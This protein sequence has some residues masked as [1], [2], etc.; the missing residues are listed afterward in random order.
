MS[1][2]IIPFPQELKPTLPTIEGNVDYRQLR[3][4]LHC[5]DQLLIQSKLEQRFVE[6]S[7]EQWMARGQLPADKI[8]PNGQLK[9]QIHSRLAL[10]CN[11]LRTYLKEDFRGFAVRLADS[12]LFQ[13][14]CGLSALDR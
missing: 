5:I 6:I 12:P 2:T 1:A 13:D 3:E 14:F 4:E 10:R 11:L 8:P 9:F 7:L